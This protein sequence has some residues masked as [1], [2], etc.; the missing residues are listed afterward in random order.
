MTRCLLLILTFFTLNIA[1]AC[2]FDDVTFNSD[3]STA[4]LDS[5]K[6]ID[7]HQYHINIEPENE[8]INPSPWYSFKVHSENK[9]NIKIK[10]TFNDNYPRY[11]PKV[12]YDGV[13]WKGIDFTTI[14]KT[15]WFT[16]ETSKTPI[17]IASQEVIDNE[18]YDNWLNNMLTKVPNAKIE[19]L[20][21]SEQGRKIKALTLEADANKEWLVIIG[22]Q[23]PPEVTGAIALLDFAE[24]LLTDKELQLRFSERF[25]LI[26]VPAVNPDGI[27]HGNW[28]HNANGLDL[29]RDWKD[30]KQIETQ[31]VRNKLENI[32]TKG[33]KIVFAIDFHSTYRDIF[34]TMPEDYPVAPQK[35]MG[36][37]LNALSN[38]TRWAFKTEIKPG[39]NP[40]KGIFKQYIADQYKVHAVTYEV[41]DKSNRQLIGYVAKQAVIVLVDQLLNTP[42]EAF[43]LSEDKTKVSKK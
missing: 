6:K 42:S 31:I 18:Y 34:Y 2:Q 40:D 36:N 23:H 1:E 32:V 10:M 38:N 15:M 5:C 20:G 33:G 39:S 43:F 37:W 21:K 7:T 28:R 22:R 4:R 11:L 16:I 9:A 13:N 29:N 41:G 14:D 17:W 8:P 26:I 3:F 30:F 35:L 25:N 27:E 12:S 24:K 19:I